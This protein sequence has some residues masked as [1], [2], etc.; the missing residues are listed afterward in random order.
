MSTPT[1]AKKRTHAVTP[2]VLAGLAKARAARAAKQ[3]PVT[4]AELPVM[5]TPVKRAVEAVF[6]HTGD[7]GDLVA[8]LPVIRH[9]GGGHIVIGAPTEVGTGQPGFCRES[10]Q[11]A[12]YEAIRPLLAAQPYVASVSWGERPKGCIDFSTFRHTKPI[13]GENIANWQARHLGISGVSLEPW[14]TVEAIP[15]PV[16]FARS[17]RYHNPRFPW[18]D[19]SRHYT[20]AVFV[21]LPSEHE[22][23]QIAIGRRIEHAQTSDLLVLT[24]MMAGSPQVL[25][26]QS[27]PFWCAAG[28]GAPTVQETCPIREQQNSIIEGRARMKYFIA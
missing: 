13:V 27:A 26:N 2:A 9:L 22:V 8:A 16:I 18:P 11:G 25:C 10:M 14:L 4:A 28:V 15:S 24:R 21:G 3:R 20:G 1:Q 23:F 17:P 7:L 19:Y 5:E 12:R 6:Y